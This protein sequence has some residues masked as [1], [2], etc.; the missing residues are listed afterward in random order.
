MFGGNKSYPALAIDSIRIK[1]KKEKKKKK[2]IERE[3]ERG[4]RERDRER[5]GMGKFLILFYILLPYL[6]DHQ[7]IQDSRNLISVNQHLFHHVHV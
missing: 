3:R 6:V 1:S 7:V 5:E 2:E 4:L